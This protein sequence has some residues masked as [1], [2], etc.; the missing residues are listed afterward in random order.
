MEE[1]KCETQCLEFTFK[2]PGKKEGG[3]GDETSL[4]KCR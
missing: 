2:Y 3:W 1:F 4:A